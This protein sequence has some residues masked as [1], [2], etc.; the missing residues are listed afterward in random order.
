MSENEEINKNE[1]EQSDINS[2]LNTEFA[3]ETRDADFSKL[4]S[5]SGESEDDESNISTLKKELREQK[6][7][8]LLLLADFDN[9]KKRVIKERSELVKYQGERVL[10]EIVEVLD[11]LERA[12]EHKDSDESKLREGLE[13]IHKQF[14]ES[15]AKFEVIQV[16]TL[17]EAFDPNIQNALSIQQTSDVEPNRVVEEFK[18]AYKYK[19]KLLRPAEVV[20]SA[21]V[22]DEKLEDKAQEENS[23]EETELEN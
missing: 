22:V 2:E 15:L 13:L 14:V 1:E 19:D 20:V 5:E 8:Y 10:F 7:K 6:E 23:I 12:L 4:D 11:N 9:F 16:S 17:G 3:E 18:K 21:A